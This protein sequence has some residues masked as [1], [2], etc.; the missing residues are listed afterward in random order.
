MKP[1]EPDHPLLA[2]T[3]T[4]VGEFEGVGVFLDQGTNDFIRLKTGQD[5]HGWILRS[6][7]ER[8]ATFER[9]DLTATLSLPAAGAE[10]AS[11]PALPHIAGLQPAGNSWMDGDGQMI[12]PPSGKTLAPRP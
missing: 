12:S 10:Q 1:A 5:H 8:E 2:L 6:V 4:V 11:Q 9:D 7:R 3:G